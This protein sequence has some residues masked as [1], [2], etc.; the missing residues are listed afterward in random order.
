VNFPFFSSVQS[1]RLFFN[2]HIQTLIPFMGQ[3]SIRRHCCSDPPFSSRRDR[4][5]IRGYFFFFPE[6]LLFD[7]V[8][9]SVFALQLRPYRSIPLSFKKKPQDPWVLFDFLP[10]SLPRVFSLLPPSPYQGKLDCVLRDWEFAGNQ[11]TH[12]PPPV[13]LSNLVRT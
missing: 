5:G 4:G 6:A 1:A 2:D 9:F 3:K 10:S 8:V 11:R 12:I 13:H 7:L